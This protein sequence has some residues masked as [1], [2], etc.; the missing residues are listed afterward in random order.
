MKKIALN[1]VITI[2]FLVASVATISEVSNLGFSDISSTN[3]TRQVRFSE[4]LNL[5]SLQVGFKT[6]VIA[7]FNSEV[8]EEA[9]GV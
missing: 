3:S 8:D 2:V 5:K 6:E 9:V 1:S 7:A 4:N